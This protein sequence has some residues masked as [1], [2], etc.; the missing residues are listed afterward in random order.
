MLVV[1]F[2]GEMIREGEM[3]AWMRHG[4]NHQTHSEKNERDA[5]HLS[6]IHAV[7][8]NHLILAL[9]LDILYVFNEKT[10]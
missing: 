2:I 5:E 10:G 6:D 7:V 3:L 9:H 4:P 1:V 8:G